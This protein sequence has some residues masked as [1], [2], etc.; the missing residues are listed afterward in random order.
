M[1][2][3]LTRPVSRSPFP[4]QTSANTS[5]TSCSLRSST[6]YSADDTRKGLLAIV[7]RMTRDDGVQGVILGCTELPL[8]LPQDRYEGVPFINTTAVHVERVMEKYREMR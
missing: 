5:S 6:A 1:P 3:R 7:R 4:P 2:P 8:I